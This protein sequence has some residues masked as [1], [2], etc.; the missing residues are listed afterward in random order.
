[1][2]LCALALAFIDFNLA[3]ME[4][5]VRLWNEMTGQVS[6]PADHPHASVSTEPVSIPE[7]Y[8]RQVEAVK[9]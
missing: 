5:A 3:F 1:M 6:S 9:A 2:M 7:M 8:R 4:S